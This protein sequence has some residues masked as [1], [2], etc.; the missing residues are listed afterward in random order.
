M[1][2][3]RA[4]SQTRTPGDELARAL[5]LKFLLGPV[6]AV[7]IACALTI[8]P[9]RDGIALAAFALATGAVVLLIGLAGWLEDQR[10]SPSAAPAERGGDT[11]SLHEKLDAVQRSVR[12]IR[13]HLVPLDDDCELADRVDKEAVEDDEMHRLH[14]L[15]EQVR[16]KEAEER[17]AA[18]RSD[19]RLYGEMTQEEQARIDAD[20]NFVLGKEKKR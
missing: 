15:E 12:L 2:T 5:Y 17:L 19:E 4:R 16:V 10:L 11:A 14:L 20:V 9:W 18:A 13:R 7:L 1:T 3:R 6:V 8:V